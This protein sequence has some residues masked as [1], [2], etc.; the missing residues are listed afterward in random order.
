MKRLVFN[1]LRAWKQSPLRK[2]LI[3]KGVRQVGKTWLLKEFGRAAYEHVAYFNF[4]ENPEYKDFFA[5]SKDPKRILP[6]LSMA[7]AQVITPGTTL[8]IFD[9]IQEAPDALNTLKY[10]HERAPEYHVACAGSLLG[11]TLARPSSFPVGQTDFLQVHPLTFTEFLL[12][13]GKTNLAAY[14]ESLED[15]EPLPEAFF[16]P[17]LEQLRLYLATGGMPE[18]VNGWVQYHDAAI[19]ER[20]LQ[21]LLDAYERDFAKYPDPATFPKLTQTWH[22]LP[23]QLSKE[24]RR[25]I[26]SAVKKGARGRDFEDALQWLVSSQLVFKVPRITAPGLPVTAYDDPGAFKIYA[27][28]IGLLRRM[29]HLPPAVFTE[30]SKPFS[31]FKGALAENY[32]LQALAPQFDTLPRY[33]SRLNPSYEVDFII[34]R[35]NEIIPVEV[36]AADNVHATS[37]KKYKEMFPEQTRLRV[38]FSMA[39]LRLDGDL[40]NIPL[41]LA[42]EAG[43]LIG[44]ALGKL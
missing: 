23:A 40:L 37:L 36:K 2:P 8:V 29:A 15:L 38:R 33:W 9:E 34:Q 27:A 4:E 18:A 30:G 25:F 12:A 22:S 31:E 44:A 42:D 35:G 13:N 1:H 16:Q 26:Y 41:F 10:F 3:L 7:S 5:K 19:V 24:N 20:T 6:N 28:D 17:L 39:N 11:I 21:N 43:R 14:M 32:V